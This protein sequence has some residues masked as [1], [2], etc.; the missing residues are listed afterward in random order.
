MT[1]RSS[2]E[3]NITTIWHAWLAFRKGKKS[4]IAIMKFEED[5][6]ENILQLY[7]DLRVGNYVH[8]SY[9]HKIINE[10]KRR[11]IYVADV[12]DRVVHRLVYDYLM[13]IVD[14]KFDVDVW[15]CRK[16]KGL[17]ACIDRTQKLLARYPG[18]YIWRGDITKF[19]DSV[20]HASLLNVINK[21]VVCKQ[22]KEL[23]TK[24]VTSY[25]NKHSQVGSGGG[26]CLN[27][28]I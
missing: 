20:P 26:A 8:G 15:S 27:V 19:F 25:S 16:S 24:I 6:E 28:R 9:T 1:G 17:H 5:L 12:R 10:K 3:I 2:I 4:S 22:S 21:E 11:D 7:Y 18:A 13:P 14:R 23:L